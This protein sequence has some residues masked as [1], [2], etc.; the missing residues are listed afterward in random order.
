MSDKQYAASEGFSR[1]TILKILGVG[2]LTAVAGCSSDSSNSTTT[3]TEMT[4]NSDQQSI[5]TTESTGLTTSSQTATASASQTLPSEQT[6]SGAINGTTSVQSPGLSAGTSRETVSSMA[7]SA[8][9]TTQ[10]NARSETVA[11]T[12][13]SKAITLSTIESTSE[14]TP[15]TTTTSPSPETIESPSEPIL[16]GVYIGDSDTAVGDFA[17]FKEW[18]NETP[19]LAMEFAAGLSSQSWVDQFI[20]TRLTP[21]WEAGSVPILTWLPSTDPPNETSSQIAREIAAGEYDSFLEEWATQL[22]TWVTSDGNSKRR[23]Y[24]RPGHEMNGNWYPWSAADSSSTA[25]DYIAM[26]RRMHDIFS[27]TDLDETTVQWIWSPNADEIGGVRAEAYYPGDEYVDW[28]GLDGFNFGDTQSYS[29]WRTPEEVFLDMLVRMRDLTDKPMALTELASSSSRDGAYRPTAKAVWI[30]RL[31][32]FVAD[33]NIR[34]TCWF[35]VEKS[36][37]DEADWAVLGGNRGTE[38]HT[39]NGET[40]NTYDSYRASVNSPA[41]IRGGTDKSPRLT[42][43]QFTGEF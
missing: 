15:T 10:T 4:V 20:T 6:T 28:V 9:S 19:A 5:I 12:S 3:V 39:V 2:G 8:V 31:F 24:F 21:I 26:W 13:T 35:N 38:T 29:S 27:D 40:Y 42:D 37:S 22:S 32:R 33:Q 34:M 36:G 18:L 16:T 17:V 43:Q 41:I 25:D 30:K 14:L 1:R 23:L 11:A 7:S